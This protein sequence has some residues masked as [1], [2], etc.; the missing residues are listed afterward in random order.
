ME[1]QKLPPEREACFTSLVNTLDRLRRKWLAEI[2]H[3]I[4]PYRIDIQ[5]QG[6]KKGKRRNGP[7]EGRVVSIILSETFHRTLGALNM[8]A[9]TERPRPRAVSNHI[10][11]VRQ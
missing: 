10:P 6:T 9:H 11:W 4:Q 3:L 2:M 8:S 1:F 7:G 5:L